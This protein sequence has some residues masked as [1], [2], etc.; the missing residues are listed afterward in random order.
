[1]ENRVQIDTHAGTPQLPI[2]QTVSLFGFRR[3]WSGR[4]YSFF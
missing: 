1:M 2:R 4:N 3:F